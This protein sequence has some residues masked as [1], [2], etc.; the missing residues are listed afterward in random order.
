M[1]IPSLR[2]MELAPE[3]T[4]IPSL[5]GGLILGGAATGLLLTNGK[6]LGISGILNGSTNIQ[7]TV[8]DRTWRLSFLS[9]SLAVASGLA[10]FYPSA[11]G[12]AV[13]LQ[14]TFQTLLAGGLVGFGT[15]MGTGCTSGHGVCGLPRFSRRSFVAVMTFMSTAAL[16]LFAKQA[17]VGTPAISASALP[18]IPGG[19]SASVLGGVALSIVLGLA[20]LVWPGDGTPLLRK[21]LPMGWG[22]LF[23]VG[24][25]LSGMLNPVKVKAFLS[26]LVLTGGWDPSLAFVMGGAV[27]LN[28]I[29]FTA[30]ISR[31]RTL[32][33]GSL[34]IPRRNDITTHLLVGSALF[35]VGWGLSGVCPGPALLSLPTGSVSALLWLPAFFV[36][37][38]AF[39]YM[40]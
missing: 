25:G 27:L 22:G 21:L 13:P 34:E 35:G 29:T 37:Q 2:E 31:G 14:S 8:S 5:V 9:G 24:L 10:A 33:N 28:V 7:T 40:F 11:F 38:K 19:V 6:I 1:G 15:A 12:P 39:N 16:T 36:G 17:I 30:I 20:A 32:F 26:P 3:F 23:A 18:A 4:P